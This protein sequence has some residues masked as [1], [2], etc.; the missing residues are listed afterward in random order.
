M[1]FYEAAVEVLKA[2]RRPLDYKTITLFAINRGLLGHIGHTPDVVM[3]SCL[4][5]ALSR[6]D[7]SVELMRLESVASEHCAD[8]R[9]ESIQQ[10][11]AIIRDV[12]SGKVI[13]SF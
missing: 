2:A 12:E 3:A 10:A 5:R 8:T 11:H 4:I 13:S 9:K 6:E 7:A 1:T